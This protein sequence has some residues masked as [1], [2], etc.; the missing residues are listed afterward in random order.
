M[1]L[2]R[3]IFGEKAFYT[4]N[5]NGERV[6]SKVNIALFEAWSVNLAKLDEREVESVLSNRNLIV[7][8]FI[9]LLQNIEF[10]KSISA[11]MFTKKAVFTRFQEI[12]KLIKKVTDA[13]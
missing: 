1:F 11:S 5:V 4:L 12:E 6:G 8:D 7:Y 10:H 2:C 9:Y 13:H 3:E